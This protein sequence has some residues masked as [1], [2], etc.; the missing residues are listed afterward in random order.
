MKKTIIASIIV[1]LFAQHIFAQDAAKWKESRSTHFIVYYNNAQESFVNRIIE[2]SEDYYNKIADALGFRRYDFWLWDKRAKIYVY[3]DA[4]KYQFFTGQPSWSAG[5]AI[6]AEKIIYTFPNEAK[7]M[8]TILPHEL[9]HIIFREFVGFNNSAI[10]LWLDEG[11]ASY[12]EA[13]KRQ[14]AMML[15][16]QAARGGNLIGI[17]GL[18][19]FSLFSAQSAESV[20]LFYAES[21]SIV[22]YLIKRFGSDRFVLF[23]QV[24]RDKKDLNE[25][26]R[27]TYSFGSIKEFDAAWQ[28]Y[29]KEF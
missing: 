21:L 16:K 1:L 12:Q 7:F 2:R 10:P 14:T 26:L 9:G 24:L 27:Y 15:V 17:D 22:D 13:D 11:V 18:G 28:K 23:C 6:S 25:A 8:E 20:S 19:S 5:A 29:I 3:D 4:Q